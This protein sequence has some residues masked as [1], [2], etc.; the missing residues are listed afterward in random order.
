MMDGLVV[1]FGTPVLA[2]LADLIVMPQRWRPDLVVHEVLEMAGPQ[3]G[4]RLEVPGVV[5]GIGPMFPFCAQLIGPAGARIGEPALWAQLSAEQALDLCPPSLQP[6][7]PPPWPGVIPLRTSAYE[8]GPV[9]PEVADVLA[10]DRPVA[11]FTLGTV[12]N[13]DTV[14]LAAGLTALA[15]DVRLCHLDSGGGRAYRWHQVDNGA[16]SSRRSHRALG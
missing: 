2:R 9:P 16:C 3:L 11:Y 15:A 1:L 7:G 13:T 10:G 6:D 14:D 12:K 5:H 8:P 4:R